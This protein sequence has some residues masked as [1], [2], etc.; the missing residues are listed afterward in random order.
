MMFHPCPLIPL[1]DPNAPP[2]Y[3]D[4]F[5]PDYNPFPP[6]TPQE[7]APY[8]LAILLIPLDPPLS[9][10]SLFAT[11]ASTDPVEAPPNPWEDPNC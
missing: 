10:D 5:P 7:I 8:R 6:M 4:L 9:Y 1:R 3:E 2:H 11:A